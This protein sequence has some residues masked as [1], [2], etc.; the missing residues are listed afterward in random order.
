MTDRSVIYL[1]ASGTSKRHD[2]SF[3]PQKNKKGAADDAATPLLISLPALHDASLGGDSPTLEH[4]D[5]R[6]NKEHW[7]IDPLFLRPIR[8]DLD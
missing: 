7:N 3:V 8:L 5:Q 6:E 4:N 1:Q 2:W